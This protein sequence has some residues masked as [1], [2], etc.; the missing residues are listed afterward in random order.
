M[1]DI[2]YN[3]NFHNKIKITYSGLKST[4]NSMCCP[5]FTLLLLNFSNSD[6][7]WHSMLLRPL[8]LYGHYSLFW[9]F[10]CSIRGIDLVCSL[11]HRF[12]W[13]VSYFGK[14]AKDDTVMC[15]RLL[16]QIIRGK[17]MKQPLVHFDCT[18]S[19]YL[20]R[21]L[22]LLYASLLHGSVSLF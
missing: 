19:H 10:T 17:Q 6:L 8:S 7:W 2:H 16:V 15:S 20:F 11:L 13:V 22:F 18:L 1:F 4:H 12:G 9:P 14:F 3:D 5:R 21:V